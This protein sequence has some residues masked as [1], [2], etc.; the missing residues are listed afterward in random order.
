MKRR[1]IFISSLIIFLSSFSL[2]F[3]GSKLLTKPFIETIE[4][5]FG[6][7]ITW[8]GLIAFPTILYSGFKNIYNA[9]TKVLRFF[10]KIIFF[11]ILSGCFW[12]VIGYFLADNWAYNFS[13]KN[14][15]RGG[16][17]AATIFWNFSYILLVL[18]VL[19]FIIYLLYSFVL[20]VQKK[21]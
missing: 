1:L 2:I 17:R 8:L 9:K 12:G 13:N 15:F 5:P 6:T 4:M 11:L 20:R 18:S 7:I 10:K 14:V 19:V 3:L 16:E 21:N